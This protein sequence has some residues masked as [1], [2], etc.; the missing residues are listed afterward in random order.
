MLWGISEAR[1]LY[2]EFVSGLKVKP[3]KLDI[4]LYGL[5]DPG[6]IIKTI[7]KFPQNSATNVQ[8]NFYVV[9]GCVELL[10]RDALLLI[11]PF[12]NDA[13]RE[14]LENRSRIS[15]ST[16]KLNCTWTFSATVYFTRRRACT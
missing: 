10:A 16:A 9:E 8:F 2:D 3:E 7:A 13:G 6:H 4:L 1:D 15:R 14:S 12:E 11:I 5:G